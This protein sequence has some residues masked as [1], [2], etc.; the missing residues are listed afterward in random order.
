M[1]VVKKVDNIEITIPNNERANDFEP[2]KK[3]TPEELHEK[4]RNIRETEKDNMLKYKTRF[5]N[6]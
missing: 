2:D 5:Q 4:I 1:K 3:L 6:K